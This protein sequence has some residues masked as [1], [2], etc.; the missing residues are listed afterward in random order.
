MKIL[1][2]NFSS[3]R[4]L[5]FY[6]LFL[7]VKPAFAQTALPAPTNLTAVAPFYNRV[8]LQWTDNS[9]D[10]ETGFEIYRDAGLG[11]NFVLIATTAK[12]ATTY[13]DN[14]LTANSLYY[15]RVRAISNSQNSAFTSNVQVTT[16]I[17]PPAAPG[18]LAAT[19]AG[20]GPVRLTWEGNNSSG[21]TFIVERANF[22]TPGPYTQIAV[23]EY[24][25]TLSYDDNSTQPGT[26]YC[27]RIMAMNS[28]GTSAY[29]NVQCVTTSQD[30]PAAPVRLA[31]TA[32][33][34]TEIR[35]AWAD[36]SGNETGFEIE[37]STSP[38]GTFSKIA[39][40]VSNTVNYSDGNL[41]AGRQYCYR[42]RAKNTAGTSGFAGPECATTTAAPITAPRSPSAL[43]ATAVSASQINLSW[44]DN[45]DNES[46]FELESS[47]DGIAF[48]KLAD[49]AAN[50]T[51]YQH[52]GL[53]PNTRYWY[54]VRAKNAGGNSGF[55][56]VADATTAEVAPAE[57]L[58]LLAL[59]VSNTQI[60]LSWVDNSLN[61]TGFEL[62]SSSD[63]INFSKLADLPANTIS[64]QNTGLK[65]L[66]T[67]WYRIRAVNTIGK[68]P[69]SGIAT[70]K[71][72]DVPPAAPERLTATTFSSSRIDL[73]WQDLS[74]NETGFELQR[75][76]DGAVFSKIAEIAANSTSYQDAGLLPAT[77][78][79]YRIRATNTASPSA[80][81]NTASATTL[82]VVPAA[83]ARLTASAISYQQVNLSWADVSGNETGFQ[84]ERSVDGSGFSKV[85]DL[86]VNVT[87]YEDKS[88]ASLTKYFY[89]IR[90][91][92]AIGFSDFS[93]VAEVT[94]PQAPLPDKPRDLTAIPLDFDLIQLRW[95][96]LSANAQL[97][98]IERSLKPDADF[99]EIGR[100]PAAVIE[101]P[102][103]EILNVADYYYRIKAVNAAGS[104]AYSD[105][106]MISAFSIIT[107]TEPA[108]E[109]D[110]V[111]VNNKTLFVKLTKP[112]NARITLFN[113][114]GAR[115]KQFNTSQTSQTDLRYL[116]AGIYFIIVETDKQIIRKKIVLF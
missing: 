85:A 37:R 98:V 18:N 105:V 32:F 106:A 55:S 13:Q 78:Y 57:P 7:F 29:S 99:V 22:T 23:V 71:T 110:L 93:N 2:K 21:T 53:K 60:D 111:Y 80:F 35:L 54:Q 96:P 82:D 40:V 14:S 97:V 79:W 56:N 81:S 1:M 27:Y 25:R 116:E 63:G 61:E 4:L 47:A 45:A 46:G 84:L 39:D 41:T 44:T 89:R 67:Y 59:P 109:S 3:N 87:T 11:N 66:T 113:K 75:S 103:R 49:L 73:S 17:A 88:V 6:A 74:T 12:N 58:R 114:L 90:A 16:P 24:S 91:V 64:Y 104:S 102:D 94:T 9:G 28:S 83:P 107:G 70:A 51:S 20:S 52:T 42:V 69:Y 72:L 34:A 5:L 92:N 36:V 101:F 68:S 108:A 65:T 86:A 48:S 19:L 26:V 50:T 115:Q 95:S 77:K 15:Y 8:N 62:E 43:A 100:Q 38:T 112:G 33:S 30:I 10:T 31:A 76:A